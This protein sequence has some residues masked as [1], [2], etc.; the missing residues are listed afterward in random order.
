MG[1]FRQQETRHPEDSL[2][3][4]LTARDEFRLEVERQ[5]ARLLEAAGVRARQIE[6][7]ATSRAEQASLQAERELEVLAEKRAALFSHMIKSVEKLEHDFAG[8]MGNF[9]RELEEMAARSE[10]APTQRAMQPGALEP[11]LT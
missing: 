7:E 11:G 9:R 8:A 4:L 6:Q 1:R 3:V 10:P 5:A 2:N